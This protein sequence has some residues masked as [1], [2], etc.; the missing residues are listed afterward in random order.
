[1]SYFPSLSTETSYIPILAEESRI[2]V[3]KS[4]YV[5]E[6]GLKILCL[7]YVFNCVIVELSSSNKTTKLCIVIKLF[8]YY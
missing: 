6:G 7:M 4:R 5:G 1:M 3:P 8:Y 2:G